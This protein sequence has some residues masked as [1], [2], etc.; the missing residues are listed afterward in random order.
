MPMLL[1]DERELGQAL[2]YGACSRGLGW[3]QIGETG[4]YPANLC[5]LSCLVELASL[6]KNFG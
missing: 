5:R 2:L 6:G 4:V 3:I 1:A